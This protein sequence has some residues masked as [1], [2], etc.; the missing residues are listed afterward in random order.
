MFK[1]RTDSKRRV[2]RRKPREKNQYENAVPQ[3]IINDTKKLHH[4]TPN[5]TKH[6]FI[7]IKPPS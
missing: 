6:L 7:M 2:G 3:R 4:C 1:Y 5:E